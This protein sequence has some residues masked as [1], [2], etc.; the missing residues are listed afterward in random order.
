MNGID[1]TTGDV[2]F[3]FVRPLVLNVLS[4]RVGVTSGGTVL[5]IVLANATDVGSF[6][7]RFENGGIIVEGVLV[8]PTL[9][10]CAT[11]AFHTGLVDVSVST[12]SVDFVGRESFLFH[13][14]LELAAVR[15]RSGTLSGGNA[16]QIAVDNVDAALVTNIHLLSTVLCQFGSVVVIAGPLANT[17]SAALVE[18]HAPSTVLLSDNADV[19][20]ANLQ[21]S[22]NGQ[23]YST[24]LEYTYRNP[25][26]ILEIE[27][28]LGPVSGG[29][30]VTIRGKNF[31][32]EA[33]LRCVFGDDSHTTYADRR[34]ASTVLCAVP[35]GSGYV[36]VRISNDDDQHH[37]HIVGVLTFHYYE[38][39][40]V[41]EIY[42]SGGPVSGGTRIRV[43]GER[44]DQASRVAYC[45]FG[46]DGVCGRLKC[47]N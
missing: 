18:C 41:T 39:I 10:R 28:S 37:I 27:P 2:S 4:P 8:G 43:V 14:P 1:Y 9:G 35:P 36:D 33:S 47:T 45:R 26:S 38:S 25:L 40:V 7:C 17:T 34:S 22:L 46:G 21:V 24:S 23:E 32:S 12:N 11:P 42:P 13:T 15:P 6:F 5:T 31:P 30:L 29:S 3:S 44:F 20:V 19:Y 16:V